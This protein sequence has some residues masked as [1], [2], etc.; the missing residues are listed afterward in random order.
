MKPGRQNTAEALRL[1]NRR[2]EELGIKTVVIASNE[3]ATAARAAKL[4]KGCRVIGVS[5]HAGYS[6]PNVQELKPEY[7]KLVE[8]AGG[9]ILVSTHAFGGVGRSIRLHLNTYQAEEIIA[10][11]LRLFGQGIKVVCEISLMA[12]DAGLVRTDQE[13]IAIAGTGRGADTAVVIQPANAGNFSN[14]GLKRSSVNHA[15]RSV[16]HN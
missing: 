5:R 16:A 6:E 13:V 2:A 3:G 12:A 7:R 14:S 1:A 15:Y 4:F 11:T 10:E 9:A 8:S